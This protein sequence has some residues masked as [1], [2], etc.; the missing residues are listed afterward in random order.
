MRRKKRKDYAF[1]RRFH[2]KLSNIPGCPGKSACVHSKTSGCA[3][4]V[5][6]NCMFDTHCWIVWQLL[7]LA[8]CLL[9]RCKFMYSVHMLQAG[10]DI[11]T[12]HGPTSLSNTPPHNKRAKVA[13]HQIYVS[14]VTCCYVHFVTCSHTLCLSAVF[15]MVL[16]TDNLITSSLQCHG[17]EEHHAGQAYLLWPLLL[18]ST[19]LCRT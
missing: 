15:V 11:Q 4:S 10:N 5:V 3:I 12:S 13:C 19:K 18:F 6:M 16:K 8:F 17:A 9:G 1:W 7:C 14:T 2:E